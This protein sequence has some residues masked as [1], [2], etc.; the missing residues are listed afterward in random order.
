MKN[1]FFFLIVSCVTLTCKSSDEDLMSMP[2]FLTTDNAKELIPLSSYGTASKVIF[3][4]EEGVEKP[5]NITIEESQEESMINDFQ[6]TIDQLAI[7]LYDES[8][9]DYK[10]NVI[11]TATYSSMNSHIEFLNIILFNI[12]PAN[13]NIIPTIKVESNKEP[14]LGTLEPE[15]QLLDKTFKDVYTNFDFSETAAYSKIYYT[16]QYGVVAFKDFEG[17]LWVYER[18]E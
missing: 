8:N 2:D 16:V 1:I 12:Q 13:G 4:N 9:A 7:I 18:V 5:L 14:L 17:K 15:V 3:K 11:A 10:I 6:Y